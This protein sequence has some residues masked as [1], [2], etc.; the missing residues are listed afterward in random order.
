MNIAAPSSFERI[1]R[2]FGR[3]FTPGRLTLGLVVPLESYPSGPVPTMEHHVERARLAESLGFSALWLRD[4]PFNVPA[5]GDAGQTFDP[6]AYLGFLAA[7]TSSIGLGVAS[8]VLPLRHPAHVAKASATVDALSGGRLLLGIASGD[9][10]EEY[11]ALGLN[12]A[13]RGARFRESYDY[14]RA[15]TRG[16]AHRSSYGQLD[17]TIELLPKPS[18][19]KLPLLITGGSQQTPEWI[20]ERGDGWMVYPRPPADQA[21]RIG[22]WRR[23]SPRPKPAMQPLYVD[24]LESPT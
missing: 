18:G 20:A 21:A 2:A 3:V 1:N 7:K 12:Y 16:D 15:V 6:F 22:A 13:Q 17:G 19:K 5:F 8:V 24:L 9:R 14:L 10:P 4:V 23:R 11:P